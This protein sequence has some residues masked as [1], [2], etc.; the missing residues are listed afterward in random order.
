MELARIVLAPALTL[1]SEPDEPA[2]RSTPTP[3]VG[4]TPVTPVFTWGLVAVPVLW[5][6]VG[7][8]GSAGGF[9]CVT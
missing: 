1:S 9:S 2:G 8:M 3:L 4:R 5:C 6:G 7:V